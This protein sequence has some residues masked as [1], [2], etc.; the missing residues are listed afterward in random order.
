[1]VR[2]TEEI[3]RFV[4]EQ[5][6]GFVASVCPDGTPNLLP[7]G[8]NDVWDNEHLVFADLRM[9]RTVDLCSA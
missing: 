8:T 6:L 4:R 5:Q 1:M 9:P 7:K 2:L 3:K